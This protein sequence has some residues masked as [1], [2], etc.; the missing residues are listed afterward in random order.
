M[1]VIA[2]AIGYYLRDLWQA[3]SKHLYFA[4][5][6]PSGY[7]LQFLPYVA[8]APIFAHVYA[9]FTTRNLVQMIVRSVKMRQETQIWLLT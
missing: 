8:I 9:L 7:I 4:I 2:F 6:I 5:Y 1:N 3:I